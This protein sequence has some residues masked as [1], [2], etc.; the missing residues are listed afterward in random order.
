MYNEQNT[1]ML[2]GMNVDANYDQCTNQEG[3]ARFLGLLGS[4]PLHSNGSD[5]HTTLESR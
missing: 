5:E 2:F 3:F 4:I 1:C